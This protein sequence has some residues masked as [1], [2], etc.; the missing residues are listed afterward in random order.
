MIVAGEESGDLHGSSLV[1]AMVQRKPELS[2]YGLGGDRL[3]EVGVTIIEH[4]HN[5]A[6]MGFTEV[7][8]KYMFLRKVFQRVLEKVDRCIP[9]RAILIDYPGFNLRLAKELKARG[10]PV[11][12]F[13][14]PQLWAWKEKRVETIQECVDQ[15]LCI[16]P[17]EEAWYEERGVQATFVGHPFMDLPEPSMTREEFLSRHKFDPEI[18]TIALM[19]GSRQ[20]EVDRHLGVLIKS[21]FS[22]RERGLNLQAVIGKAPGVTVRGVNYHGVSVEEENPQQALRFADGAVVASGTISFEAALY[23]TPAVVIYRLSPVTWF[24][25][26]RIARV[27]FVS[28]TNLIAGREVFP[29]LLQE[30]ATPELVAANL[31]PFLVDES[32]Q[33]EVFAGMEEV[34]RTMGKPGAA[35]RAADLIL[36]RLG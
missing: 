18:T 29:E 10:I 36:Q 28:M 9:T 1:R 20:Q 30:K 7:V 31:L 33:D 32:R 3:Q 12:Y 21:L 22:L 11:T 16:F 23:N 26:R 8:S 5:I 25:A 4:V 2:F 13:I 17:F 35:G 34:Q 24:F 15:L 27:E 6:V 19:P 14:S